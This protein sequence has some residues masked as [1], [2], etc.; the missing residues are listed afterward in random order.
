MSS[1][2]AAYSVI[3]GAIFIYTWLMF[4]KQKRLEKKLDELRELVRDSKKR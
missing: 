3:F 2:V 1:L 4:G